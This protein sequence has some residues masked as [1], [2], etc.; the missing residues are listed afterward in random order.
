MA[1]WVI[2]IVGLLAS[3][4]VAVVWLFSRGSGPGKGQSKIVE[5]PADPSPG[6]IAEA[7]ANA[8]LTTAPR[9]MSLYL[10]FAGHVDQIRPGRHVL[11]DDATPRAIRAALEHA[12]DRPRARVTFPEGTHRFE[13]ARR[14]EEKSIAIAQDFLLATQD[15][16]L[17]AELAIPAPH[18]EGYLFP[19]TYDFPV[20]SDGAEIVRRLKREFDARIAKIKAD[21]PDFPGAQANALGWSPHKALTLASIVEKEAGVDEERPIIASVFLNRYRD[22]SFTPKPPRLQSDPTSAYGCRVQPTLPACAGFTGKTTPAMNNDPANVYSTY[23]HADLPPTP[24]SNPGE[25]SLRGV[26]AP[27][28]T[29][30]LYF[31]AKGG[32]RHTFSSTLAEHNEAVGKLRDLRR[33]TQPA[34]APVPSPSPSP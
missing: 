16:K 24:I 12:D 2:T 30:Y 32:N 19:S 22:P 29:K 1:A 34:P 26:V 11:P 18:A 6:E 27:A 5:I 15:P 10:R 33:L 7:L 23:S 17:L 8:G 20:D 31:V 4:T 21:Y 13:M 9:K 14:L 3:V 25:A 28:D